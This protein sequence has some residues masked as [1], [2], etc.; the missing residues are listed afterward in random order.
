MISPDDHASRH[1][2]AASASPPVT[3][4]LGLLG[5]ST[6]MGADELQQAVADA[7]I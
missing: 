1:L 7:M 6:P 4:R 5:Q 2:R 3:S